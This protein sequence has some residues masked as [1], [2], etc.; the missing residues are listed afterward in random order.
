MN[1]KRV[2]YY[3]AIAI[4]LTTVNISAQK[5]K[6]S[7]NPV[8]PGWYADPEGLVFD[9]EYWIFPTYSAPYEDQ[10]FMDAFSSKDLVKWK[11][12]KRIIDTT[13]VKWAQKAMWAP[14]AIEKEGKYYLLVF[15]GQRYSK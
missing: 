11:K 12:H 5:V 7:G 13:E 8:F 10:I 1:K 9:D 15:C 3:W 2:K 14:S 4:I 6:T